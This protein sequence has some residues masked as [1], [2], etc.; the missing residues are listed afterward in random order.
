MFT[1]SRIFLLRDV[2]RCWWRFRR[3][4]TLRTWSTWRPWKP[5]APTTW[6]SFFLKGWH[7]AIMA[8]APPRS[9]LITGCNRGIGLELVKQFLGHPTPP[10]VLIATCRNPDQA[11][12]LQALVKSHPDRLK[13]LPLE[14]TGELQL[15]STSYVVSIRTHSASL[16]CKR[17]ANNQLIVK[18]GLF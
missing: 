14:M 9:V 16:W 10:E 5:T 11:E 15:H 1:F 6:L 7:V 8:S 3:F 4:R 17:T 13:V 18:C 2:R 12:D